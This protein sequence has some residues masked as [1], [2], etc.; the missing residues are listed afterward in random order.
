MPIVG[1]LE[2]EKYLVPDPTA[3]KPEEWD[4]E[5]DGEWEA[6]QIQVST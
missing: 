1:W 6:P 2:D 5:D 4:D 3:S